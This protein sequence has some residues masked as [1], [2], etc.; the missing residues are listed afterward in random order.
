LVQ[1]L[2]QRRQFLLIKIKSDNPPAEIP[3]LD[4]LFVQ[5]VGEDLRKKQLSFLHQSFTSNYL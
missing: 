5:A 2:H 1:E 4:Q 3:Q